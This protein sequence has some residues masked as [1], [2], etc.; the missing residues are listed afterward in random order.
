M[1]DKNLLKLGQLTVSKFKENKKLHQEEKNQKF[2]DEKRE[3]RKKKNVDIE[4]V[5][6]E[7]LQLNIP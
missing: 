5:K 1:S 7:V 6:E 3:E 2:F 4:T